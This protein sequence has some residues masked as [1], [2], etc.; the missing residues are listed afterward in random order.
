[1]THVHVTELTDQ[2]IRHWSFVWLVPNYYKEKCWSIVNWPLQI[3]P[4]ISFEIQD[5]LQRNAFQTICKMLRFC[6]SFILMIL[7]RSFQM[8]IS[9]AVTLVP[10]TTDVSTYQGR[11][12]VTSVSVSEQWCMKIHQPFIMPHFPGNILILV[13]HH[14]STP[15]YLILL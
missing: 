9:V 14:I 1:M 7:W 3:F 10:M 13:F 12:G 15:R 8:E 6:V 2:L 4:K 11:H 5:I